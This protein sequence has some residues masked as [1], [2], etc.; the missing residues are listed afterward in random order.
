LSLNDNRVLATVPEALGELTSLRRLSIAYSGITDLPGALRG[1]RAITS[2]DLGGNERMTSVPTVIRELTSLTEFTLSGSLTSVPD[3][4]G[5][6]TDLV[7]LTL[8]FNS[9]TR[10][11]ASI[12][13]L[14]RLKE[15]RLNRNRLAALPDTI[16]ELVGLEVLRLENNELETVP[17][18]IGDLANLRDL[19]LS[20]NRLTEFPD[21][22]TRLPALRLLSLDGNEVTRLPASVGNLRG[23]E[24]LSMTNNRLTQLPDIF[25]E[26]RSLRWLQVPGNALTSLP[27]SIAALHGEATVVVG[28]AMEPP[29]GFG[30]R[31]AIEPASNDRDVRDEGEEDEDDDDTFWVNAD[32]TD[33]DG[34]V[35]IWLNV[36]FDEDNAIIGWYDH[37]QQES[38]GVG[39][40]S[41]AEILRGFSYWTSWIDA[42][43]DAGVALGVTE[44]EFAWLLYDSDWTAK[45]GPI[46][47]HP[48]GW[49]LG[50]FTYEQ[51]G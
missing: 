45:P 7:T 26:L 33:R 39:P 32:L 4:I 48:G 51:R 3:W 13:S 12:G 11:P 36:H 21:A 44:A 23:L 37:D 41:L 5:E 40:E 31:F 6:L 2:L 14:R 17:D 27:P 28:R 38:G 25:G 30:G 29:P 35:S 46:P 49:Y 16:G 22:V 50:S 1:L 10:V 43:L 42:A 18:S 47:G 20:G 15:L 19:S 8:W 24:R 9:L 34:V